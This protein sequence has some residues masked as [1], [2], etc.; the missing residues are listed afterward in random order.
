MLRPLQDSDLAFLFDIENNKSNW[1]FG[2]EKR[3]YTKEE[4]L[5]YIR[6]SQTDIKIAKQYRF[7]IDF[8]NMPIGFI[9]LFNYTIDSSAV[10]I[11]IAEDYRRRGFAKEALELLYIYAI[12]ILDLK[13]IHCTVE[14]QN[15]SSIKLFSACGFKCIGEKENLKYFVR[16]AEN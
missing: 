13:N 9:D 4:L 5:H 10:G 6:N 1:R 16:L 14:K 7:V 8:N 3:E 12:T 15:L 2:S 11:I